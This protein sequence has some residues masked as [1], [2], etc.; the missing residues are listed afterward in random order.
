MVRKIFKNF[1]PSKL[2][3]DSDYD[4]YLIFEGEEEREQI[5][6]N[7]AAEAIAKSSVKNITKVINIKGSIY[8]KSV[9][10]QHIQKID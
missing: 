6:A 7:S 9:H 1:K 4:T 2:E 5:A 3:L 10:N 8:T